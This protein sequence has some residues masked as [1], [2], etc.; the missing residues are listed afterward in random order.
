MEEQNKR[1]GI[2]CVLGIVIFIAIATFYSVLYYYVTPHSG[3]ESA[4]IS[5]L[6]RTNY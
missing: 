5:Q 1:V 4:I 3:V 6:E 2:C